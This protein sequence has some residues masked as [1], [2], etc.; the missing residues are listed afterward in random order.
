MT[1]K[2]INALT[3]KKWLDSDEALLLDVR[4]PAEYKAGHIP[5]AQLAPLSTVTK[6]RVVT[7]GGKKLVFQCK[8]GKR[9]CLAGDKLLAENPNLE[10]YTL[11]GG[12]DS[13]SR[14]GLPINE[15]D[16]YILPVDQQVQLTIGLGVLTGSLLGYFVSP[17]FFLLTGFFGAGLTFA[18]L[19]GT[20]GLAI[21]ISKMPWNQR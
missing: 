9:S 15:G 16:S 5:G 21:M 14:A 2:P 17:K 13:W 18:G 20:C 4:E 11:D 12:I 7:A 8:S 3:L 10:I 19:S 1:T 6:E